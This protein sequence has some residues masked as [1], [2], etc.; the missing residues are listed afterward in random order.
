MRSLPLAKSEGSR[1]HRFPSRIGGREVKINRNLCFSNIYT[2]ERVAPARHLKERRIACG[3]KLSPHVCVPVPATSPSWPHKHLI[4]FPL[5]SLY[6]Q[7]SRVLC[8]T[9]AKVKNELPCLLTLQSWVGRGGNEF[10]NQLSDQSIKKQ[11]RLR[12][13]LS[14]APHCWWITYKGR[15]KNLKAINVLFFLKPS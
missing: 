8:R 6:R 11:N 10:I 4:L 15:L 2:K 12:M 13:H 9:A 1:E 14:R 3:Y 7:E 5:S